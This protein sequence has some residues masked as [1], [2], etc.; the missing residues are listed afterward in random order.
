M[1]SILFFVVFVTV[2]F[3]FDIDSK[4]VIVFLALVVWEAMDLIVGMK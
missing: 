4:W 2:L 1:K 3:L